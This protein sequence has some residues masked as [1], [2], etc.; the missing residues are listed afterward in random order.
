MSGGIAALQLVREAGLGDL[1]RPGSEHAPGELGSQRLLPVRPE[2]RPLFPGG[3]LRRGSVIAVATSGP[4]APAAPPT[5]RSTGPVAD[6]AA[7]PVADRPAATSLLLSVLAEAS[8]AGSWCA[9]VG[10]PT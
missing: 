4:A 7:G 6:R 2:L 8:K 1:V 3:G 10:V 9:V 5:G